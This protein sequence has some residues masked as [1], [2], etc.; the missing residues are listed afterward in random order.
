MTTIPMSALRA[1]GG[2]EREAMRVFPPLADDHPIVGQACAVCGETFV[3]GDMT[4]A[5]PLGP[6]ADQDDQAKAARGGW[7]SCWAVVG[8]AACA[9]FATGEA[10]LGS[11]RTG[12]PADDGASS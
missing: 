9:G 11:E 7:Y 1:Q 3:V 5:I 12:S 6:G 10:D 2:R 4:T 8:H